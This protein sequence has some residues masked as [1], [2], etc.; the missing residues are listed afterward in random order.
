M[1]EFALV[2]PVLLLLIYGIIEF[3]RML[4]IYSSVT[5]ASREAARYGSA[6]NRVGGTT[7]QYLDCA[8]ILRAAQRAAI[9]TPINAANISIRYDHGP[10][11]ATI[12]TSCEAA[13]NETFVLG[14]RIVVQV[15]VTYSPMTG[16]GN[17]ATF[18]INSTTAR[19][20]L[21][22]VE[23][24]GTPVASLTEPNI[25]F[26]SETDSGEESERKEIRVVLDGV[27]INNITVMFEYGG[28]AT[29]G[30]DYTIKYT[31]LTIPAGTMSGSI[32]AIAQVEDDLL[33]EDDETI[34]AT[35]LSANGAQVKEPSTHT[36]TILNTATDDPPP[37]V[38]FAV[39]Q[40]TVDEGGDS[41][42]IDIA[43]VSPPYASGK[44]I[45]VSLATPFGGT[46]IPSD[47]TLNK[48]TV[49][50][51]AGSPSGSILVTALKDNLY[52]G[53]VDTLILTLSDP[54]VNAVLSPDITRIVHTVFINDM[55][56]K[57]QV[58]FDLASQ[59]TM[60]GIT[61]KLKVLM[62]K[63]SE[64]DTIV[65]LL[66]VD[67]TAS[68]NADYQLPQTS[69]TIPAG[70]L[71][72]TINIP[73]LADA[74]VESD[75]TFKVLID[76]VTNGDKG[77]PSEHTVT[78][79]DN[80][81]PPVATFESSGK[82]VSEGDGKVL[83]RIV[84]D[85]AWNQPVTVPYSVIGGTATQGVT[86]DYTITGSEVIIPVG[87]LYQNV[88]VNIIDDPTDEFNETIILALGSPTYASKGTPDQF[89]ITIA[90]N[91]SEP[92][93]FFATQT[94]SVPENAGDVTVDVLLGVASAKDVTASVLVSGEATEGQ[95]YTISAK[96]VAIP[97][98][99]TKATLTIKVI[100]DIV[101]SEGNE[102]VILTLVNPVNAIVGSPN[103]H[104]TSIIENDFCPYIS[105]WDALP[106]QGFS[107]MLVGFTY[108]EG[109]PIIH[110]SEVDVWWYASPGQKL[111]RVE[112]IGK[113]IYNPQPATSTE[114]TFIT[115]F[116]GTLD[117]RMYQPTSLEKLMLIYFAKDLGGAPEDYDLT[118][119]FDNGCIV[120]H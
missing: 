68:L 118:V 101:P 44:D 94:Q 92:Q 26:V 39:S 96:S 62:D 113:A 42:F 15:L 59:K 21:K 8:G 5:T 77:T 35:I 45:Q 36:M 54:P 81:N 85:H 17:F 4:F 34:V 114:P 57:P 22:A 49:S 79:T 86:G 67:G 110:I 84:L 65:T 119:K 78:I 28:T 50:I 27:A 20:I 56:T 11:T 80:T 120:T 25:Y 6:V 115:T 29:P 24:Q 89:V 83:V 66:A 53:V 58:F 55:D 32:F 73:I 97:A 87:S 18:P 103:V 51:P 3:G 14:D 63:I 31:T 70:S 99:S 43:I 100:D 107:T 108:Y 116:N 105:T 104:T 69:I 37:E 61:L 93:I 23:V 95:D 16:I 48:T 7:P 64:L 30:A 88:E 19:T 60:E 111:S 112:W 38:A 1:V 109:Q 9:I 41:K 2:F 90:D 75:E 106:N 117:D 46:A 71:E 52:E 72:A 10:G 47:Y 33:Y 74:V 12:A 13:Q 76:T 91:D 102:R 98:G 82:P 40:T